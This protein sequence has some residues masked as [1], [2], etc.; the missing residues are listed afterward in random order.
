MRLTSTWPGKPW[1]VSGR[2]PP[3]PTGSSPSYAMRNIGTLA[4]VADT[5]GPI[6]RRLSISCCCASRRVEASG[7]VQVRDLMIM[8]VDMSGDFA[9]FVI[10]IFGTTGVDRVMEDVVRSKS[11]FLLESSFLVTSV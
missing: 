11:S 8:G 7:C 9:R 6:G 10:L 1:S 3:H 4:A 5:P 2:R